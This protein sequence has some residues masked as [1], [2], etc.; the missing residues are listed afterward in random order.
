[1][2]SIRC[3]ILGIAA[4]LATLSPYAAA[5]LERIGVVGLAGA[6]VTA[7]S[8]DGAARTLKTGDAVYLND[9]V[10][11]DAGGKA[12]LIFLDRSTLTLNANTDLTLDTYVYDPAAG[13]GTMAISGAKGAF[14]FV[15]GVLSK[16]Q[17]VT[18]KTPVAT[19]GIRGGIVDTNVEQSGGS[20]DAVFVYGEE[21][22]MANQKGEQS[23]T[24]QIGTGLM[25][26]NPTGTPAPMPPELVN[27]RMQSFG[28]APAAAGSD[29][30]NGRS[31][32]DSDG[33]RHENGG[34][35][36]TGS[37]EVSGNTAQDA[38]TEAVREAAIQGDETVLPGVR[39]IPA[40]QDALDILPPSP[41]AAEGTAET[42]PPPAEDA[43][44]T[45]AD[46]EPSPMP[47]A[48]NNSGGTAP[49]IPVIARR[50]FYKY[51][52]GGTVSEYDVR[53]EPDA[54][55][56]GKE[57]L[58]HDD[59]ST[60][61]DNTTPLAGNVSVFPAGLSS[62]NFAASQVTP[63][64]GSGIS[65]STLPAMSGHAYASPFGGMTYLQLY[66]GGTTQLTTVYGDWIK[67][68][69]HGDFSTALADARDRSVQ[70]SDAAGFGGVS[71]Y[72]FLPDMTHD[73]T[74][75]P[76]FGFFNYTI[77]DT[78]L[79]SP[80]DSAAG[81]EVRGNSP[82]LAVDWEHGVVLGMD[83]EFIATGDNKPSATIA[84]GR[85]D[86]AGSASGEYIKGNLQ[87]FYGQ[88]LN[89]T[90][91]APITKNGEFTVGDEIFGRPNKPI[92]G[93]VID[94]GYDANSAPALPW[95][96]TGSQ[97][98]VLDTAPGINS[99][100]M[101]GETGGT[102]TGFAG[103]VVK[104]N[105]AY[106][107]Y[108]SGDNPTK[109]TLNLNPGNRMVDGEITLQ[110]I[111][112][113]AAMFSGTFGSA[114]DTAKSAYISDKAFAAEQTG[115]TLSTINAGFI[116]SGKAIAAGSGCGDCQYTQWGVW[117][118]SG[119]ASGAPVS[120]EMIPYVVGSRITQDFDAT[121]AAALNTAT[122]D[123]G[124][125]TYTGAAY[126]NFVKDGLYLQNA[127]G[128]L[129]ATVDLANREVSTLSMDFGT[130]LGNPLTIATTAATPI[131][132]SGNAVFTSTGV[133]G[134]GSGAINGALFGPNAEEI[135][136]NFAVERNVSGQT[137]TGAGV[138]HGAR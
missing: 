33:S 74:A 65:I 45:V 40:V 113:P 110:K 125:A 128:T 136:G 112:A 19:I 79:L 60:P 39:D 109:V 8:E 77:A 26:D 105:T 138:F 85:V 107:T 6:T 117:A 87:K 63:L 80:F 46:P 130:V 122:G 25:L 131:A 76:S 10:T 35:T 50:G 58:I 31:N 119:T 7:V 116:A 2:K 73:H 9:R 56:A 52:D 118:A 94:Y 12:Q 30:D 93:M 36:S 28:G 115:G 129:D 137:L 101:G 104:V 69:L 13:S 64:D 32:G 47:N 4:M 90:P 14:R 43:P 22:T 120:A 3:G 42:M 24:T 49:A 123:T 95:L 103:G 72:D 20:T 48:D 55:T 18:I 133:N 53:V 67:N 106:H 61:P 51:R 82:G 102:Y 124:A 114:S 84:I 92:E 111:G 99:A 88:Q 29:Q 1:M 44:V 96:V 59:D 34:D 86:N 54:M 38:G 83:V 15:G 11:S 81:S 134:S 91:A 21:L 37:G 89:A 68:S 17:P 16:K 135:G 70:A 41:P 132:D 126:G 66:G 62:V 71:F 97:A 78:A 75:A 27:Q 121:K 127:V 23:S 100:E 57:V 108:S 98:A 5:A